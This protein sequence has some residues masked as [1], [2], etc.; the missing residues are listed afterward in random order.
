MPTPATDSLTRPPWYQRRFQFG[1]PPWLLTDLLERLRGTVLRLNPLLDALD[2]ATL[3][4]SDDGSW[5]IA[6]NV[7]HLGDTEELWIQRYEDLQAGR[8]TFTPADPTL[9]EAQGE[10]HVGVPIE[11]TLARVGALRARWIG[12]LETA[13]AALQLASA[14]HARLDTHMRL[15]D[16]AQFATHHDD[17]HL[18]RIRQLRAQFGV[19]SI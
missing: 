9:L 3:H 12:M 10:Q 11:K 17:S 18:V 16:C 1:L 2:A 8:E 6:Q 4:R 19:D 15:V 7:G 13:P 5:S 14:F